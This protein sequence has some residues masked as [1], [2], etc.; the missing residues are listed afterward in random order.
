MYKNRIGKNKENARFKKSD[1]STEICTPVNKVFQ[2]EGTEPWVAVNTIQQW[3]PT[4]LCPEEQELDDDVTTQSAWED[5]D[6]E[7][8]DADGF[9]RWLAKYCRK[10]HK[11]CYDILVLKDNLIII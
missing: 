8:G 6:D 1:F 5:V 2:P 4:I 11:N 3:T 10:S 7:S 9:D